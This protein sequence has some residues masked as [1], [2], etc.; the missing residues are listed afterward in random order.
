MEELFDVLNENGEFTGETISRE[1]AHVD[2]TYHRAVV[3]F[4]VNS[5]KQVLL[6]KRSLS[7]KKWGGYWD[8]TSGGH[9]EAGELGLMSAIRELDEELGIKVKPEDVR[10]IG[11]RRTQT[12]KFGMNDNHFNEYFVAFKEVNVMKVKL[13]KDEVDEVK[14]IDFADFKNMVRNKNASLT[15]KWAAYEY[16]IMFIEYGQN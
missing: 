4:L 15:E 12:P 8:V 1:K 9:V 13:Q 11:C 7:K 14:W 2:G 10:Y 3:L 16:L 6:Q 5:K